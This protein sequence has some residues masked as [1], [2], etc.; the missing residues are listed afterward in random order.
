MKAYHQVFW[1]RKE[2]LEV[3]ATRTSISSWHRNNQTLAY[4]PQIRHSRKTIDSWLR[5]TQ[6]MRYYSIYSPLMTVSCIIDLSKVE[7]TKQTKT[8]RL[9]WTSLWANKIGTSK[10]QY[11]VRTNQQMVGRPCIH[12]QTTST[13]GRLRPWPPTPASK[14]KIWTQQTWETWT[15]TSTSQPLSPT[16]SHPNKCTITGEKQVAVR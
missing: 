10:A 3:N 14:D 15:P 5:M 16:T 9:R 7:S 2:W 11:R 6:G 1:N 13:S 8:L 4:S 12:S